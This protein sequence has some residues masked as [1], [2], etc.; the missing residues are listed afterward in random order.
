[1]WTLFYTHIAFQKTN[2]A[3]LLG[4]G[5]IPHAT[6]QLSHN[7][8]SLRAYSPCSTTRSHHSEKPVHHNESSPHSPQLEKACTQQQRPNAAKNKKTQQFPCPWFAFQNSYFFLFNNVG[9]KLSTFIS[10]PY[11]LQCTI[12]DYKWK[13]S[14]GRIKRVERRVLRFWQ[15]KSLYRIE[16]EKNDLGRK[17]GNVLKQ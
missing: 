10:C 14:W 9:T 15:K 5:K 13:Q 11:T 2:G 8:W 7:Y 3:S 17:K 1:M 12:T 16:E 6:E 4:S